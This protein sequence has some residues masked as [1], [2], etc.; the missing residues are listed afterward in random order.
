MA[1]RGVGVRKQIGLVAARVLLAVGFVGAPAPVEAA[2]VTVTHA[3]MQNWFFST[4]GLAGPSSG[5][6]VQG[7]SGGLGGGSARLKVDATNAAQLLATPQFAG[8]RLD[9]LT[10][11]TYQTYTTTAN[12][13][14]ALAFDIDYDLTD[15]NT[16]YQGRFVFD[17]TNNGALQAIQ[18]NQWQTWNVLD[19]NAKW[20]ATRA[21]GNAS[22][23]ISNP[24]TIAQILS[25]FPNAGIRAGSGILGVK[26]GSGWAS[27]D[28]NVDNINVGTASGTTTFDFE[29]G[30]SPATLY[31][32]TDGDDLACNGETDAA[33]GATAF[34]KC[35]FKTVQ[36]AVTRAVAG[37]TINVRAGTFTEQVSITKNLTITGAGA[38]NTKIAVPASPVS[39]IPAPAG[40]TGY[41]LVGVG[42]NATVTLSGVTLDGPWPFPGNC[43]ADFIG[44]AVYGGG[45]LSLSNSTVSNMA[46][47]DQAGAGGCQQGV[48]VQIGRNAISQVGAATLDSVTVTGFQK[49][50]VVIDGAGSAGTVKNST[51][52]ATPSAVI[53][54]NG[55]QVSRGAAGTIGPNNTISGNQ[56]NYSGVCG[57]NPLVDTQSTGIILYNPD[58]GVTITGNTV[59][60]NDIGIYNYSPVNDGATLNAKTKS[61]KGPG[62][63]ALDAGT[64]GP[65]RRVSSAA[66]QITGNTLTDNRYEGIFLDE[67]AATITG[68]T[69]TRGNIGVEVASFSGATGDS[70][71]SLKNNKISDATVAGIQLQDDDTTDTLKPTISGDTNDLSGNTL[72]AVNNT[73]AGVVTLTNNWWGSADGPKHASNTF[74]VA[75]QGGAVSNNV[76]FVPWLKNIN[77]TPGTFTGTSFAPVTTDTPAGSYA[78]IQA[79]I[80][81]A[82]GGTVTAAAGTYSESPN[83]TKSLT[84]KAASGRDQTTIALQTG[85][86]YLGSLTIGASNVTV[87]GFR[88]KGFDGTAT[89][90]A[91]TNVY[92]LTGLSNVTLTNSAIQVGAIND[93]SSNGDDG[94]GF[95]T[96]Y[97]V[98]NA[99]L[100]TNITVSN[101]HF[102]PLESS[103]GFRA[104][105]INPGVNVFTFQN[106]RITGN[107][108]ATSITQAKDGTVKDNNVTGAG[109]A[110]SR[111]AGLGTWGSP[112]PTVWGKTTFQNNT[113]TGTRRGLALYSANNVTVTGNTLDQNDDGVWIGTGDSGD[114][115]SNPT[116]IS[117]RQNK[118]TQSNGAAIRNTLPTSAGA[119]SGTPN[120]FGLPTGPT[121]AANVGGTGGAV[122]GPVTF[123]PWCGNVNCTV[124]YGIPTKLI[125]TTQPGGAVMNDALN[126]QPAVTAQD[127]SGNLAINFTGG[128][129][130]A[131][132][133][134]PSGGTLNGTK[135]VNAGAGVATFTGLSVDKPGTGYTLT[136]SAGGLTGATSNPF[137]IAPPVPTISAVSPARGSTLGGDRV[138]I[139]GTN[140]VAGDVVK[141]DGTAG[142]N[143]VVVNSTTITVIAPAHAAGTVDVRVENANSQGN[144]LTG[145]YQYATP[146][147]E[148]AT[149]GRPVN[150]P[151]AGQPPPSPAPPGRSAPSNPPPG[152]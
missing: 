96:T 90:L 135:T 126:P 18:T 76:G 69:V 30:T 105:Y 113:I 146:N 68:N 85:P 71:G 14:P 87:D 53:A 62:R 128:V 50:G 49:A 43:A 125:F 84:L 142:T 117:I 91:A 54:S 145:A 133:T 151:P 74:N 27:F 141:F 29:P 23:P 13:A 47:S 25:S 21:P 57:P 86:T 10:T 147:P 52:T 12:L 24:C 83:I 110:G 55:V 101:T 8:T 97:T 111:S 102:T 94:I 75:T 67:G 98:D 32:R 132:G 33:F 108:T 19:L 28:G 134:N 82:T 89:T 72:L 127:A 93:A 64:S 46:N 109:T 39:N 136:A 65:G 144:T 40:L 58:G 73:T 99:G 77:G 88:I 31:V 137:T 149:T 100:S 4:D 35:A 7:P 140:F 107:F 139:T 121:N 9:A 80:T 114:P 36:N 131:L 51:I 63:T 123:S 15:T 70:R 120:W 106:N 124:L 16:A 95:L 2:G 11:L 1:M 116:T 37:D 38:A 20:F 59:M 42:T 6:L 81:T 112:D 56:C 104:F 78:S 3:D 103:S 48:G 44:A 66:T 138:T 118:I 130:V 150:I 41:A 17:T 60:N 129:T 148:P 5:E 119:A 45:T 22:C 61:G 122:I 34:P 92:L 79:G 26:A 143:V 152:R 115:T